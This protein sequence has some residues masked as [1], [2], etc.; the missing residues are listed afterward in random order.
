[1]TRSKLPGLTQPQGKKKLVPGLI[2]WEERGMT[3]QATELVLKATLVGNFWSIAV[4]AAEHLRP[5]PVQ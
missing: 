3:L 1:M 4:W 5:D 2:L